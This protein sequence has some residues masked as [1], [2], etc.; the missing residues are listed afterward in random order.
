MTYPPQSG[1][2]NPQGGGYPQGQQPHGG[3]GQPGQQVATQA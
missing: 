1:G 3:Y 2:F